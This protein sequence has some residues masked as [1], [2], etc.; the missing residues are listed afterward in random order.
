MSFFLF[1]LLEKN[2]FLSE[3]RE[4]Q[5]EQVDGDCKTFSSFPRFKYEPWILP[6]VFLAFE[7]KYRAN[8]QT[9]KNSPYSFYMML[10]P[11]SANISN[12]GVF[13]VFLSTDKF[14]KG[15]KRTFWLGRK[16]LRLSRP[17]HHLPVSL[18][19]LLFPTFFLLFSSLNFYF[20][21]SEI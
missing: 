12:L 2:F 5:D 17:S 11:L 21:L 20:Y 1:F 16:C 7:L 13:S 3:L 8:L 18:P 14:F 10:A 4:T 15:K 6:F 19:F 9:L